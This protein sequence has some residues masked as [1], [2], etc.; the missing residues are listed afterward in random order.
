MVAV[1]VIGLAG[2]FM[3]RNVSLNRENPIPPRQSKIMDIITLK[4][5]ITIDDV[6]KEIPNVT[7]RT[8]RRDLTSLES[9]GYIIKVGR[10]KG[11]SY[12]IR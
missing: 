12:K 2:F 3:R 4:G 1:F 8:L 9:S 5:E 11:T 10:T 7:R 6:V